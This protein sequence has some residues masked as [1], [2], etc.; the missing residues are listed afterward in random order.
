MIIN[1]NC[2]GEDYHINFYE[3]Y[4][5]FLI[6]TGHVWY[7]LLAGHQ[8]VGIVNTLELDVITQAK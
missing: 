6:S 7:I 3:D 5:K 8:L 2:T 1:E 4:L